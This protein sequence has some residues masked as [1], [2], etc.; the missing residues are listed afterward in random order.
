[1]LYSTHNLKE[2]TEAIRNRE[3]ILFVGA[4]VSMNLGLPSWE[5]LIG[6]LARDL[7]YEKEVYQTMG[8]HLV[9]AEYYKLIKG[10]GS[11]RSW[12]DRKWHNTE[13][14]DIG[15]SK[16][17]ELIVKLDF[18]I[19]YT[20]NYDRWLEFAYDRY[21]KDYVKIV[22]VSDLRA[23]SEHATQIIKFHGDF[24][25][26]DSIVLTESSFFER[27][28]FETPLD[29]KL[30]ADVLGRSIL[31][32]G[33]SLSDINIRFLLHKLNRLW[34]QANIASAK[35]KS[36]MLLMKPNPVQERVLEHRGITTIIS[37]YKEPKD[38]LI[39][40]LESLY[41]DVKTQPTEP[42]EATPKKKRPIQA[43]DHDDDAPGSLRE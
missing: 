16:I 35:P 38:G 14:I 19:I 28:D 40:F 39:H 27:L 23:I 18:P 10:I 11:L 42:P 1:M 5:D 21:E 37:P 15:A 17:H 22:D 34:E 6:K 30:R 25:N 43:S 26:D 12:M 41:G 3:V 29:I 20:T 2:L 8:D 4:G 33:Y 36:F 24:D 31:F 7:G 32:L 9:L 13:R